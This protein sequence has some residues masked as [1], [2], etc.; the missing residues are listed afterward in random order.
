MKRTFLTL[1][2]CISM[3]TLATRE[4]AAG[5]RGS[6]YGGGGA[7][8]GGYGGGGAQRGGYGGGGR[9]YEGGGGGGMS[10]SPSM[11]QPQH[12]GAAGA[13]AG[14]GHSNQN[15]PQ[16][17]GAAGAAAGAG[18]SNQ[19][20][21]QHAGAAGAAAGA[22]YSNRNQPQH[23]GAA[24][25][26]AG[27]GYS[28]RNQPQH[29]D[30]AGAAAGAGYAN[31]NQNQ[32]SNAGAAA[33]GAAYANNN[34]AWNGNYGY[35]SAG[36]YGGMGMAS[37]SYG[38]GSTPYVNPYTSMMGTGAGG[39]AGGGQP[40]NQGQPANA[41]AGNSAGYDYTQPVNL[42]AAPAN[43]D[44]PPD[45]ATDPVAL[46]SQAFQG[47]DY[48]GAVQFTQQ[49]LGQ[50]P[51]DVGLH[52]LLALGLFAQGKY[53]QAAAPLYAVLA[54]GPGWDWTTLIGHYP[55]ASLY[56]TQLRGLEA[57]VKANPQSAKSRFVEAYQY[58][59]Q[60][61][62][63]AAIKPLKAVLTLQPKDTVSAQLLDSLQPPAAASLAQPLDPSKLM[64]VWM[65]QAAQNAKVTLTI[66][67][68]ANFTWAFAAQG[69]PPVTI[70]GTYALA[71]GVLTLNGKDAPGGPLS[72]KVASPDDT[73]MSFKAI[74]APSSDPGLQFAR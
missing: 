34:G 25:A 13:A 59:C 36:N 67:D 2:F 21:P 63:Q 8:R 12:S 37:P 24:G 44:V 31:R 5:G 64:G 72:G 54:V 57:Y 46:A 60:G 29:P 62:G 16:H 39:A 18:H 73:H 70:T 35:G 58:I 17:A 9:S 10:H 49:A 45:P 43:V 40:V 22:G 41:P 27:A 71:N 48:A 6:G 38:Y 55:D 51:N 32:Y 20:Q 4:A 11:S 47:G 3:S 26:A 65:A 52:Q 7:Q 15:Q 66:S 28:N 61:Q 56:T 33:A 14:A 42:A 1:A 74:G 30:A 68:D 23:A 19:N 53:E 69:K 50:S